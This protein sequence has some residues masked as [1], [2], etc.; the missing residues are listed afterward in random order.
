MFGHMDLWVPVHLWQWV[1]VCSWS[2]HCGM[3]NGIRQQPR[4]QPRRQ[5]TR[6]RIQA[7][8][9]L[10][11]VTWV[12]PVWPQC[13]QVI[14]TGWSGQWQGGY[15]PWLLG[16]GAIITIGCCIIMGCPGCCIIG[17]PGCCIIG[18]PCVC[19]GCCMGMGWPCMGCPVAMGCCCI[20][21]YCWTR[22]CCSGVG[23]TWGSIFIIER[24]V[25]YNYNEYIL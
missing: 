2:L 6:Q 19:M 9:P 1:Q 15:A 13:W 20:G 22:G 7:R 10:S 18:C 24:K 14:V 23:L 8:V 5:R 11:S 3:Q 21:G 12:T 16:V 17:W 25:L 4:K